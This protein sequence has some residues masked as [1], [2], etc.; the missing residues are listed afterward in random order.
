[1][2]DLGALWRRS[3]WGAEASGLS[4][5]LESLLLQPTNAVSSEAPETPLRP[6]KFLSSGSNHQEDTA[7]LGHGRVCGVWTEL[8]SGSA[9][10]S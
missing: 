9:R 4:R 10:P 8:V 2:G 3:E 1:M 6:V 5:R 7:P